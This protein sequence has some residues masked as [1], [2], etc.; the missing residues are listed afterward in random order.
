MSCYAMSCY[1]TLWVICINRPAIWAI[2]EY[3]L[4]LPMEWVGIVCKQSKI[5]AFFEISLVGLL[6][7]LAVLFG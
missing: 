1:V 6:S 5:K 2:G 4:C 7:N 3:I